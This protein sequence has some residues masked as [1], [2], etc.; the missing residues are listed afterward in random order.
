SPLPLYRAEYGWDD[1]PDA[2][3]LRDLRDVFNHRAH[4]LL[5]A[6]WEK[7]RLSLRM[8]PGGS[9]PTTTQIA[10]LA[11]LGRHNG[12]PFHHVDARRLLPLTG[13]LSF[14]SG[15]ARVME[16]VLR[17]YFQLPQLQIE[18][19]R[20][21]SVPVPE[22]QTNAM[23]HQGHLGVDLVL[24]SEVLDCSGC[25]LICLE[26]VSL[27]TARRFSPDA[28]DYLALRE[29]V[30]F[31]SPVPLEFGLSFEVMTDSIPQACLGDEQAQLGVGVLLGEP[32][33]D[34]LRLQF[35]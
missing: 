10:A 13:L 31:L 26:Q 19:N 34:S 14:N 21:R 5:Q 7:Y 2:A 32:Q 1:S 11:R 17:Y 18:P 30:D 27:E 4:Q 29:L 23:G 15:S 6:V 12:Y 25:F 28:A 22:G 16:R 8:H 9:D 33:A 3:V 20:L 24:G 35:K